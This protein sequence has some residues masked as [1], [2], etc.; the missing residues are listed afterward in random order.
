[1]AY[2]SLASSVPLAIYKT[3]F[4]T[5]EHR[6]HDP[7]LFSVYCCKDLAGSDAGDADGSFVSYCYKQ[8][9]ILMV[10]NFTSLYLA[11]VYLKPLP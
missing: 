3:L 7:T 8:R 10:R 9:V 4:L 2:K 1:M 5:S 6:G 11:L